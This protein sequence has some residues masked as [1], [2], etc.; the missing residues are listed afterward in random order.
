MSQKPTYEQL[1]QRF[2]ELE[3]DAVRHRQAEM[4]LQES[5]ARFRALMDNIPAVVA[6]GTATKII[7]T[8]DRISCNRDDGAVKI[9][10]RR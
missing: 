3:A 7:Q 8:G 2:K 9:V 5:E 10:K 6:R 4:N 1:E